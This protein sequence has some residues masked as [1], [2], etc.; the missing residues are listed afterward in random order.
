MNG[1]IQLLGFDNYAQLRGA[2]SS[3][4]RVAIVSGYA[5]ADDGGGGSFVWSDD[6]SAADDGGIVIV[7]AVLP[8]KGCWKRLYDGEVWVQWFGALGATTTS[9]YTAQIN[10][11]IKASSGKRLHFPAGVFGVSATITIATPVR[12][13]GAGREDDDTGTSGTKISW[14]GAADSGPIFNFSGFA[15]GGWGVEFMTLCCNGK[16]DGVNLEDAMYGN[17]TSVWIQ[18]PYNWGMR[19]TLTP[20]QKRNTA[21]NTLTDLGIRAY[22]AKK[23]GLYLTGRWNDTA[24]DSGDACFNTFSG[25]AISHG[26]DTPGLL[27]GLC[28]NNVF[29]NTSFF[30]TRGSGPPPAGKNGWSIR[31]DPDDA[32]NRGF[33]INNFFTKVNAGGGWYQPGHTISKQFVLGYALDNGGPEPVTEGSPLTW[34]DSNNPSVIYGASLHQDE[35]HLVQPAGAGGDATFMNGWGNL[36][37]DTI[38]AAYTRDANGFVHLRGAMKG[39]AFNTPAFQLPIGYR[40][41]AVASFLWLVD[42]GAGYG[43]VD[44]SGNVWLNVACRSFWAI[45]GATF[46]TR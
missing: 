38:S 3:N 11:A 43:W 18:D 46:D 6:A 4:G 32:G 12:L 23:A 42:N 22:G 9:D 39:G 29:T 41:S 5:D 10:A 25:L 8:R 17:F 24:F 7:P 20:A 45:D 31:V 40:P 26:D 34:M 36:G 30:P 1:K 21:F 37:G 16:S 2:T 27:L 15:A 35:W 28:D 14:V 33:P 44:A 13:I 19:L